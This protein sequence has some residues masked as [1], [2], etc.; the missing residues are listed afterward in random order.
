MK[1]PKRGEEG[2]EG[3][4][5]SQ[6]ET[7]PDDI[8]SHIV[9]HLDAASLL[10][11]EASRTLRTR[12]SSFFFHLINADKQVRSLGIPTYLLNHPFPHVTAIQTSLPPSTLFRHNHRI[13]HSIRNRRWHSAQVG[14]QWPQAVIPVLELT[15][16]NLLLGVGGKLII[17]PLSHPRRECM[18]KVVERERI[19]NVSKRSDGSRGDIVGLAPLPD[20]QITVA[21]YDGTIQRLDPRRPEAGGTLKST[22]HYTSGPIKGR[23]DALHTLAYD[24]DMFMTTT[25]SQTPMAHIYSARSPWIPPTSISLP[26]GEP[27]AWASLV[28]TTS[29]YLPPTVMLGLSSSISVYDVPTSSSQAG[30]SR[31]LTGPDLPARSSAYDIHLPPSHS[32]HH[33]STLLSAWYDSHLRL[34]DLRSPSSSPVSEFSDPWIWAD[35]SAMYSSTWFGEYGIAGGGARHGTVCLFDIR[36][37]K[38]GWSVFSPGGKGSPVYSLKGEGGKVWGVTE[39]RAF[40]LAFD[41]SGDLDQG[42]LS[43]ELMAG[44]RRDRDAKSKASRGREAPASWKGRGGRRIV[45]TAR[46]E[47]DDGSGRGYEH[48]QRR[49]ELFDGLPMP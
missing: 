43:D 12:V 32:I 34:H 42:I 30:P 5:L 37:A 25:S 35:G 45:P 11:L 31:R 9:S 14:A 28:S 19:W 46:E 44:V 8:F 15:P 7:I 26:S 20:G 21:Q 48:S 1:V 18:T 23:K 3:V 49:V 40:V 47:V 16:D 24:G 41:G 17:H 13:N 4:A 22:A 2:S 33:P 27:R 38:K 6:I 36:Y 39:K 10:S 29:K